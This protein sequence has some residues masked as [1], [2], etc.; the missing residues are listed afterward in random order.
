MLQ[1]LNASHAV[2]Y[3]EWVDAGRMLLL[4]RCAC[5]RIMQ[6]SLP[7][8]HASSK[9][10][11]KRT[12]TRLRCR[13]KSGQSLRCKQESHSIKRTA[14]HGTSAAVE[15]MNSQLLAT[16]TTPG[17][18]ARL[19]NYMEQTRLRFLRQKQWY[20][21]VH[22]QLACASKLLNLTDG[23]HMMSALC[24]DNLITYRRPLESSLAY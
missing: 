18:S 17:D 11:Q 6:Q 5:L 4:F 10:L 8:T 15:A 7:C 1:Q 2:R 22:I 14:H 21:M 24:G 20:T 16:K 23:R 19:Y 3:V 13:Q 12:S 9:K